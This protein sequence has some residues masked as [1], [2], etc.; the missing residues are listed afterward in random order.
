MEGI[1]FIF[2]EAIYYWF[3]SYLVTKFNSA[4]LANSCILLFLF[5]MIISVPSLICLKFIRSRK[6]FFTIS[7]AL[8]ISVSLLI[9]LIKK[10][11]QNG[12]I[13]LAFHLYTTLFM[14]IPFFTLFTLSMHKLYYPK[15]KKKQ[16][17]MLIVSKKLILI[18]ISFIF[19]FILSFNN[20]I[21][22]ISIIDFIL[23]LLSPFIS[24]F[25]LKY[26]D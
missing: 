7:S 2:T 18:I 3:M 17:A 12:I 16:L 20:L 14:L 21:I 25:L 11:T 5:S 6:K 24:N 10:F 8:I 1:I 23:N 4:Y 19:S 13:N 26:L 15:K 9:L 22:L